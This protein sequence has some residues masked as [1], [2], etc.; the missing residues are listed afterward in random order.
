MTTFD[1]VINTL[2]VIGL[3]ITYLG[4]CLHTVI[5]NKDILDKIPA[6]KR[7]GIPNRN[8]TLGHS[9]V[10]TIAEMLMITALSW[11]DEYEQQVTHKKFPELEDKI[12]RLKDVCKPII[13]RIKK[14]SG[15]REYRN[16]IIAHNLKSS[17][18]GISIFNESISSIELKV[19]MEL[20]ELI[21]LI[22][23]IEYANSVF[24][25]IFQKEVMENSDV[26]VYD[27]LIIKTEV[28][29]YDK[30]YRAIITEVHSKIKEWENK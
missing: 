9:I 1:D 15:I 20:S 19:P 25:N 18:G 23:L 27:K 22:E 10:P 16:K 29:D 13:R 30:E 28:I 8:S 6:N 3:K 11:L 21:L 4:D 7:S 24:F 2:E 17:P 14:W 26:H 12:S 5:R